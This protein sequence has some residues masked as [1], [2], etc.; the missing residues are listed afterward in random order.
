MAS[1][2]TP[3]YYGISS[4]KKEKNNDGKWLVN[5]GIKNYGERFMPLKIETKF[6]DGSVDLRW[7]KNHLWRYSDTFSYEVDNEP[8]SVTID[9]EVRTVDLDFRN[10][11]TKMNH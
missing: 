10:N 6:S 8:I 4:F 7:W 5:L 1:Y 11:S 3:S 2:Y 9:P